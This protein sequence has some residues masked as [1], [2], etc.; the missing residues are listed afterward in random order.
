M[1][2]G[3]GP[4]KLVVSVGSVA[5][6]LARRLTRAEFVRD[7]IDVGTNMRLET[8]SSKRSFI[9]RAAV[10][11]AAVGVLLLL[12]ALY[13]WS[14]RPSRLERLKSIK[15]SGVQNSK[16]LVGEEDFLAKMTP[17]DRR[18]ASRVMSAMDSVQDIAGVHSLVEIWVSAIL[19][20]TLLSISG[21]HL[22]R[23][24]L[25]RTES[26]SRVSEDRWPR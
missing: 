5:D 15:D 26:H 11:M 6:R 22:I 4:D 9:S 21:T 2:G 20:I 7:S 18:A 23:T 14:V 16:D 13:S 24:G 8:N 3:S 10:P 19:G 17:A 12:F 25:S 1:L